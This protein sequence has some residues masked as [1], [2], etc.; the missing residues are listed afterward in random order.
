MVFRDFIFGCVPNLLHFI[1]I[2]MKKH[3]VEMIVLDMAGT[4]IEEGNIVYKT[5]HKTLNESGYPVVLETVLNFGAGKEKLKAVKD[6]LAW[7]DP[8]TDK[9]PS[10]VKKIHTRFVKALDN[11]YQQ[12]KVNPF[13]GLQELLEE[14]RGRGIRVVLNTGYNREIATLLL[15]KVKW[16]PGQQFDLL[17]TADDVKKA[18]PAPDMILLAM[19]KLGVED[20]SKV[21]K[22]GDSIVDIEEGKA[23]QCGITVG[24]TTGAH[25][26]EQLQSAEPDYILSSI[27]GLRNIL[28]VSD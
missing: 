26:F 23:A 5:L 22:V 21:V 14:W 15:K 25:T 27:I 18:R 7:V 17:V 3:K 1:G 10:I 16:N 2:L 9:D 13:P 28:A 8:E 19:E 4:A 20:P 6:I 24:V 12:M 11:A